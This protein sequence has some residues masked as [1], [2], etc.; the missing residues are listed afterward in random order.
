MATLLHSVVKQLDCQSLT[1]LLQFYAEMSSLESKTAQMQCTDAER[2]STMLSS[3]Q[4]S[5]Q[6]L[7]EALV[8]LN[9]PAS[10]LA[11]VQ[12]LLKE[13]ERIKHSFED[14]SAGRWN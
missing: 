11:Q 5:M 14:E 3:M 8:K 12:D 13:A 10:L 7:L 9:T 2:H 1:E 4:Q 6:K